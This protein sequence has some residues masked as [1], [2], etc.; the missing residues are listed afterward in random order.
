MNIETARLQVLKHFQWIDGHADTWTMLRHPDSL[1]AIVRGLAALVRGD[2][3][4]VIVGIETRG[5]ALGLAVAH[6]L[7]I[8]FTPIRK[9]GSL[10]PGPLVEQ[11][12]NAGYRGE[13]PTL[14]LR[15]DH[16]PSGERVALV[17]DWI[18]TGSQAVA[19][20][21][22]ITACGASLVSIAVIVDQG[23]T[24]ARNRLPPIRSLLT[25]DDLPP[26]QPDLAESHSE[27]N[28]SVQPGSGQPAS[29]RPE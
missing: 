14:I 25:A 6:E 1:N 11:R 8:G 19:A 22:L 10:F 23:A 18:E 29:D 24:S 12:A 9:S 21:E 27:Q 13:R 7:S 20:S 5:L 17:D 3:P 16:L 28:E 26:Y 2:R 4:D 15:R